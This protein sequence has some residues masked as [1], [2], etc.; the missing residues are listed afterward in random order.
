MNKADIT[1]FVINVGILLI[2][3]SIYDFYWVKYRETEKPLMQVATGLVVGCTGILLMIENIG[4][5]S[6]SVI[7]IDAKTVLLSLSGLFFGTCPTFAAA[8]VMA[9]FAVYRFFFSPIPFYSEEMGP[10]LWNAQSYLTFDLITIGIAALCGILLNKF[11]P[12]WI[13]KHYHK[14]L[15]LLAFVVHILMFIMLPTLVLSDKE[16][17]TKMLTLAPTVL[18]IFPASVILLGKLMVNDVSRWDTKARLANSEEKFN[19]VALCTDDCFWEMDKQ[20]YVTYVSSTVT[21]ILGYNPDDII[22]KKPFEFISGIESKH[23]LI[24]YV[25]EKAN[26]NAIFDNNLILKH[27]DGVQIRCTARGIKRFD[28][29]GNLSGYVGIVHNVNDQ[30]MQR[31]LLRHNQMQLREQNRQYE[32]L[33]NELKQNN[34]KINS[35]NK[36][37]TEAKERSELAEKSKKTFIANISQEV[38]TPIA[39]INDYLDNAKSFGSIEDRSNFIAVVKQQCGDIMLL[40]DEISDMEKIED[41]S[42][43]PCETSGDIS[44]LFNEI[45]V[46]YNLRSLYL[47]NHRIEFVR[48]ITIKGEDQ[49]VKT[50][51]QIITKVLKNLISNAC[52]YTKA[53]RITFRCS[54]SDDRSE[55]V[56]EVSDTGIGIDNATLETIFTRYTTDPST[57]PGYGSGIGLA[58]SKAV[59]EYLGGRIWAESERGE[60]TS[61]YVAVPYH[62]AELT[63][64]ENTYKWRGKNVVVMAKDR[65]LSVYLTNMLIKTD[66]H[67]KVYTLE[68]KFDSLP[69]NDNEKYDAAIIDM[70]LTKS[71]FADQ[72]QRFIS[73]KSI[74]VVEADNDADSNSIYESLAAI[75]S[76]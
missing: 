37:L 17:A 49:V 65:F 24:G 32:L 27:K 61:F 54:L 55:I 43:K 52:R 76:I 21:K 12:E 45:C 62:K 5:Y 69:D 1:D 23:N 33:N 15:I 42:F 72:I 11:Q 35:I 70:R 7:F 57:T 16:T 39:A 10:E 36:A 2:F 53:G 51:F 60:G 14:T 4:W 59:I 25:D 68:Q 67:Y 71:V 40:L 13:S 46:Y 9:G 34:E 19:N 22:G 28:K 31:E 66:V 18:G 29:F 58:V 75:L 73:K 8:V 20:G 56:F 3:R 50:D 26:K 44:Y 64:I 74:P 30:Y 38:K 48:E 47:N 41:G 63:S 6:G